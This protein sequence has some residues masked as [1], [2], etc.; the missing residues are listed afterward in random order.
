MLD[1][2]QARYRNVDL[3]MGPERVRE[4]AA[5]A[6]GFQPDPFSRFFPTYQR[7]LYLNA[8][9]DIALSFEG[10]PLIGCTTFTFN[11]ASAEHEARHESGPSGQGAILARAFDFEVDDV[12]DRRKAIFLVREDGKIPFASVAWP[13]LVGVVSGMNAE[14]LAVVVHGGRA[15]E[16]R[17]EGE[18]VVHALRRVLS[19]ARDVPEA[20][21]RLRE[22]SPLVGHLI[23]LADAAGRTVVVERV[24]GSEPHVRELPSAAAVTNHFEGPFASDPRNLRVLEKTSTRDRRERGDE[25][26]QSL[27]EPVGP[28]RAVAMLR[29]RQRRQRPKLELGDRRAI[30]ALIATHGVVMQTAERLLWVSESPHLLGRF[31]RFDLTRLLAPDYDPAASDS[32]RHSPPIRC[33]TAPSTRSSRRRERAQTVA[34][35]E[36]CSHEPIPPLERAAFLLHLE[37]FRVERHPLSSVSR[38]AGGTRPCSDQVRGRSPRIRN[39]RFTPSIPSSLAGAPIG[40]SKVSLSK[41]SPPPVSS[42]VRRDRRQ[43]EPFRAEPSACS[44]RIAPRQTKSSGCAAVS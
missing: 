38:I 23:V 21:A 40:A 26:V 34:R 43:I 32:S 16:P 19:D 44:R 42:P 33:S 18:P 1:L 35:R 31:V 24:P 37:R 25:L 2:A 6:L 8:L 12:F 9:Y 7:F 13:G 4:I 5:G 27:K 17:A 11:G 39:A 36:L 22:R 28:A 30:D 3:G 29:D 15:G 20:V 41:R 10:S 14:G